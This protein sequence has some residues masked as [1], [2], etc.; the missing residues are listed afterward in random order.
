MSRDCQMVINPR[1][2]V[3]RAER[4]NRRE[5]L[6]HRACLREGVHATRTR[7]VRQRVERLIHGQLRAVT[8]TNRAIRSRVAIVHRAAPRC[9]SIPSRL[10]LS[11]AQ[12]PPHPR[13]AHRDREHR[14]RRWMFARSWSNRGLPERCR[15]SSSKRAKTVWP[16]RAARREPPV[17][18][19]QSSKVLDRGR[20]N[21]R[22]EAVRQRDRPVP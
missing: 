9:R 11:H 16:R 6:R 18:R 2:T 12:E 17:V 22:E 19:C 1:R 5:S 4:L 10:R 3:R 21:W 14:G 7:P 13:E 15:S 20:M 8:R